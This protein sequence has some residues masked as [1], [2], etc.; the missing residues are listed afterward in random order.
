MGLVVDG[1]A[2]LYVVGV[3]CPSAQWI[4]MGLIY[5]GYTY[6]VKYNKMYKLI[7]KR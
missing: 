3:V 6:Y 2:A 1:Y 5:K 7:E 4:T